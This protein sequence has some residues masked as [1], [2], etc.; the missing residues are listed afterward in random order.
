MNCDLMIIYVKSSDRLVC[1]TSWHYPVLNPL[2]QMSR[3][4]RRRSFYRERPYNPLRWKPWHRTACTK[5][6]T[7]LYF[8][9][10]RRLHLTLPTRCKK[11]WSWTWIQASVLFQILWFQTSPPQ[12]Y[13]VTRQTSPVSQNLPEE[14]ACNY[15]A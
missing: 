2:N 13:D 8:Q 3:A 1:I 14:I 6:L 15:P 7:I 12:N 9:A 11:L 4:L 10:W 5:P